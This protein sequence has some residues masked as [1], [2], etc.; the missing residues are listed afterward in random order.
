VRSAITKLKHNVS[1]G[2]SYSRETFVSALLKGGKTPKDV[3][4]VADNHCRLQR[5]KEWDEVHDMDNH[6]QRKKA[7]HVI[8]DKVD[9]EVRG[10]PLVRTVDPV[11]AVQVEAMLAGAGHL[12]LEPLPVLAPEATVAPLLFDQYFELN[13]KTKSSD[14]FVNWTKQAH[15]KVR[16]WNV[17]NTYVSWNHG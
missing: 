14:E 5:L 11:F 1:L 7:M 8:C 17:I 10:E 13:R 6:E 9:W 16:T 15:A 12:R 2:A 3:W 4:D